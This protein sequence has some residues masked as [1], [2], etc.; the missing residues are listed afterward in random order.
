MKTV[1]ELTVKDKEIT[2]LEQKV[3]RWLSI[4]EKLK[5]EILYLRRVLFGRSSERYAKEDPN[6]LKLD[7]GGKDT[8][9]E[10]TQAQLEAAKETITEEKA[11]FIIRE[12]PV[13][14]DM[15]AFWGIMLA[16]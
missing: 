10:E 6:Q 16:M 3:F 15:I 8:L 7:F 4:N 9:T 12:S 11:L 14:G 13:S 5:S 2:R 1:Q